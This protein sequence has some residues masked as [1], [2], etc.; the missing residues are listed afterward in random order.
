MENPVGQ[1]HRLPHRPTTSRLNRA[2]SPCPPRHPRP[3]PR[4]ATTRKSW[5]RPADHACATTP[6]PAA[7][8]ETRQRPHEI[9]HPRIQAKSGHPT[10]A[11]AVHEWCNP[12]DLVG[13]CIAP[14]NAACTHLNGAGIRRTS[15]LHWML[16]RPGKKS[17]K[18]SRVGH[19]RGPTASVFQRP[20]T[21]RVSCAC[22]CPTSVCV[23]DEKPRQ[24]F[25]ATERDAVAGQDLIG[26]DVQA[27]GD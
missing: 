14:L 9:T 27:L 7:P 4:N 16:A 12:T 15:G 20:P 21:R 25:R 1:R 18:R 3:D 23:P 5:Y 13:A 8:H 19:R 24:L 2:A 11:T 17:A 26:R 10:C 6:H 22:I